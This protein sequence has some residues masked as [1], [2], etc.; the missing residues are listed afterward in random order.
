MRKVDTLLVTTR[1]FIL[2]RRQARA[3]SEIRS[4]PRGVVQ[5][6]ES[7]VMML[8]LF[9]YYKPAKDE[10]RLIHSRE[11]HW[12]SVRR[13]EILLVLSVNLEHARAND[14]KCRI[15]GTEVEMRGEYLRIHEFE[16]CKQSYENKQTWW[17]LMD[18]TKVSESTPSFRQSMKEGSPS[19]II[20]R[21]VCI[22][23]IRHPVISCVRRAYPF[24]NHFPIT[25]RSPQQFQA[26]LLHPLVRSAAV[27]PFFSTSVRVQR[28]RRIRRPL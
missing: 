5:L 27:S 24:I 3:V 16:W 23:R 4:I 11:P 19:L 8:R 17:R 20:R 22:F 26:G 6:K 21:G 12:R 9:M 7:E 25:K 13:I 28:F 10:V 1:L 14:Y 2:H 15:V 18:V